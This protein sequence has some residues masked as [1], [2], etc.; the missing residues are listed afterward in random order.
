[1]TACRQELCTYWAGS[2][3]VC[4]ALDLD[5]DAEHESGTCDCWMCDEEL[6]PQGDDE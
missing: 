6:I 1:M 4:D 5:L 2:D 3:C